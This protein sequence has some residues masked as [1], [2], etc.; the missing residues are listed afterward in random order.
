MGPL[1]LME[2]SRA[3]LAGSHIQEGAMRGRSIEWTVWAVLACLL[4]LPALGATVESIPLPPRGTWVVDT[5]GTLRP[6][7]LAEVN[8]IGTELDASGRGQLALVLVDSTE[9]RPPREF[10]TALFNRWGIGHRERDDGVLLFVALVDR[11]VEIVLGDGV[12]SAAHTARSDALMEQLVQHF[13]QGEMDAG[14]LAGARGVRG[15]LGPPAQGARDSTTES[16]PWFRALFL[17]VGC[18][19]GLLL[20]ASLF[21]RGRPESTCLSCRAARMRRTQTTE[22]ADDGT[23]FYDISYC[24]NCLATRATRQGRLDCS[25]CRRDMAVGRALTLRTPTRD[26]NGLV[27]VEEACT[28]CQEHRTTA[29][30]TQREG[31]DQHSDSTPRKKRARSAL[32]T[33]LFGGFLGGGGF[34]GGGGFSGGGGFGGGSS[35]GGG[36]SGGY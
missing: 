10:A 22:P 18:L 11:K 6:G 33:G 26:R 21:I 5:T 7:T 28:S 9:G 4:C 13:K 19:A 36:S 32:G 8:R 15:L 16:E 35:S 20:L 30:M 12:D 34:F 27:E 29:Y 25:Q 14:A 3:M 31:D 24:P 2:H 23:A 17:V 1:S